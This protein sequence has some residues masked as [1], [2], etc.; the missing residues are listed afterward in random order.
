MF[1]GYRPDSGRV[2]RCARQISKGTTD[3]CWTLYR[4]LRKVCSAQTRKDDAAISRTG[5]FETR[6]HSFT[7]FHFQWFRVCTD[8][9][10]RRAIRSRRSR[11][12]SKRSPRCWCSRWWTWS[13]AWLVVFGRVDDSEAS[14]G[15]IQIDHQRSF[16]FIPQDKSNDESKVSNAEISCCT[17]GGRPGHFAIDRNSNI[18][19]KR[20]A[21]DTGFS[22][23]D[24][25]ARS[26]SFIYHRFTRFSTS[27]SRDTQ[28]R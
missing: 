17:M 8:S 28:A 13:N 15:T 10:E 23:D 4:S 27:E 24:K 3:H 11:V 16:E 1:L 21:Q 26:V 25:P 12:R 20:S 6:I 2:P 19:R 7:T 9:L 5:L 22:I 18:E 14:N